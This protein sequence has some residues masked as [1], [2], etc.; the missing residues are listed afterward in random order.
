MKNWILNIYEIFGKKIV[1]KKKILELE[2]EV[3]KDLKK[4]NFCFV[5]KIIKYI[6]KFFKNKKSIFV[7]LMRNYQFYTNIIFVLIRMHLLFKIIKKKQ[8]IFLSI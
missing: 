1:K 2:N 5:N 8:N 3:K 6:F 4:F 7:C